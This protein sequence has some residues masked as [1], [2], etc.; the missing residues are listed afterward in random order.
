[1]VRNNLA[2]ITVILSL[3]GLFFSHIINFGLLACC[4]SLAGIL[5]GIGGVI[6]GLTMKQE[7][8]MSL[9]GLVLSIFVFLSCRG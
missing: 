2:P 4:F 6:Q 3:T 9:V 1:M 8:I 7:R 5:C